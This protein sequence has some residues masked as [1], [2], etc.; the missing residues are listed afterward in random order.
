MILLQDITKSFRRG[1]NIVYVLSSLSL[2]V[3][4]GDYIAL[5]GKSGSGKSTLLNIIGALEK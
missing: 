4:K 3:N 1:K 5:M 2:K